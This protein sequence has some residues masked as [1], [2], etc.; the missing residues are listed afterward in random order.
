MRFHGHQFLHR[1]P[2]F[3]QFGRQSIPHSICMLACTAFFICYIY[4]NELMEQSELMK[5]SM[6]LLFIYQISGYMGLATGVYMYVCVLC[7]NRI[8]AIKTIFVRNILVN[9][10]IVMKAARKCKRSAN[11]ERVT[12]SK[13]QIFIALRSRGRKNSK[14]DRATG[15]QKEKTYTISFI[16]IRYP[17][18]N[19]ISNFGSMCL[20]RT[21]QLIV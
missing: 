6:I 20:V 5:I 11:R 17:G 19:F 2:P 14:K 1:K 15:S 13:M 18:R 10:S 8:H 3:L 4:R 9:D 16:V 12:N 7:I 21:A